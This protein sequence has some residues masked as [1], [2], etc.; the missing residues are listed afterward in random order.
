MSGGHYITLEMR[1]WIFLI[2]F[3][4]SYTHGAVSLDKFSFGGTEGQ[5]KPSIPGLAMKRKVLQICL[6]IYLSI[7]HPSIHE[8]GF[9]QSY[10]HTHAH[11]HNQT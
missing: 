5:T 11:T 8:S 3:N 1:Y 4:Y 6:S 10:A 2:M 9:F 7:H